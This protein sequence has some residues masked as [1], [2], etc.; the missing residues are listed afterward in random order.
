VAAIREL[1]AEPGRAAGLGAAARALVEE[2]YDWQA[3]VPSL[4]AIYAAHGR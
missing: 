1:H 3:Y 4:L 2:R